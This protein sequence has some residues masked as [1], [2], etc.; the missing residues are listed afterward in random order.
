MTNSSD[1]VSDYPTLCS[2]SSEFRKKWYNIENQCENLGDVAYNVA[3]ENILNYDN[4]DLISWVTSMYNT[5]EMLYRTYDSL[6]NQTNTNWEWVLVNDSSDQ[7][8]IKIANEIASKD[9]EFVYMIFHPKVV[10]S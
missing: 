5:G 3:M 8:T 7:K 6:K 2:L 10:G 9:S 1:H 4:T